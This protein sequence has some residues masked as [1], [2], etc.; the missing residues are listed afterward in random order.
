MRYFV[1]TNVFIY[2]LDETFRLK[3]NVLQIF[4]DYDNQIYVSSES[5]KEFI[6]LLQHNRIKV[7][8]KKVE[9][10]F[11]YLESFGYTIK[12]IKKE[13]LKTLANLPIEKT[14][15]DPSDRLIIAQAITEKI[16]VISS[17]NAFPLYREHGLD[18]IEN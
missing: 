8:I 2:S 14:H 7:N 18:L 1:D 15:N 6:H 13:H 5:I 3:K 12:Y 16:P 10:I 9:D 17:D 4:E 11:D